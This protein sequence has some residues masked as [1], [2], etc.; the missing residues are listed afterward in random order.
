M[1]ANDFMMRRIL[2]ICCYLAALMSGA[3]AHAFRDEI[4]YIE[5]SDSCRL[6]VHV[7]GEGPVCLYLHGGPGSGSAWM[8]K[9]V[10]PV[11][12]KRF[13]MVYLDQRGVC[14]SETPAGND[15][16]FD[17]QIRDWEE[18]RTALG[19]EEWLLMGH[20]WGGIL[21]MGYWQKHPEVIDGMLFVNCTLSCGTSMEE[22]W[23][24]TAIDILG[25][26][27]GPVAKDVTRPL[28]ECLMAVFPQLNDDNRWRIFSPD[29]AA[30]EALDS[31]DFHK[32]CISH[33]GEHVLFMDEYWQDFRS[34][35]PEVD[36]PVLFLF[37]T[38]DHSVGPDFHKG[39]HFPH[40]VMCGAECGHMIFI[41]EPALFETCLDDYLE[42]YFNAP[43]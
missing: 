13:T 14:K 2:F 31:P 34:L 36:V 17:R 26:Q 42:L 6:Y 23:L 22:S 19:V 28:K 21:M 18:V 24:P 40:A 30:Y 11:L 7:K 39:V 15:F 41:E 1:Y 16:S 37:G 43:H 25:D 33:N 32:D 38:Q 8:E 10:G 4:H 5:T 12:E 3:K 9:L 29:R 20:S 35:T 27:A